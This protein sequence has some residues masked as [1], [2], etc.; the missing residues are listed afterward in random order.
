MNI[1]LAGGIS[2]NRFPLMRDLSMNV[3]LAGE[4]GKER[5]HN[6]LLSI[7]KEK[8]VKDFLGGEIDEKMNIYLAGTMYGNQGESSDQSANSRPYSLD[9]HILESFYYADEVTERLIP[10]VKSF[11]LDS[12]AF[13][14][15]QNAQI[16]IDWNEYLER[17]ADFINRNDVKLFFELDIDSIVGYDQVKEY[18]TKLERLTNKQPI[19]V[20]HN[21][22]GWN[23]FVRSCE[24]YPY[25][26]LGGIAG[27]KWS[28]EAQSSMPK[29]ISTAHKYKSKIH[30]LGFTQMT[31]LNKYHFDSVDSTA[32]TT[33][34]RFGYIY[35]FKN[36][37]M[38]KIDTPKGMRL[39]D[40]RK[41]ALI[42]FLEWVKFAK[43]A[44]NNL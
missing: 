31:Y 22:R 19:I 6:S 20:W 21:N 25:V 36:G 34:N 37:K 38:N 5:S 15:M 12:G 8:A 28:K 30:G 13:T 1:I 23:D 29:F 33:G 14:F 27:K 17:Y 24:E 26:A 2:G 40:S 10:H 18:R 4:N 43:W 32:W 11:M 7:D 16:R 3:Y 39:A 44:E 41:V 9:C 42:N 35:Q